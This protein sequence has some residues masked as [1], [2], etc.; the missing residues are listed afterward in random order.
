VFE[1]EHQGETKRIAVS[2]GDN[3]FIIGANPYSLS[4]K[5]KPLP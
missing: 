5:V 3:G 4:K 1:I 2:I